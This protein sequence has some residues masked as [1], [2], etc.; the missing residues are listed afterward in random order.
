MAIT[1]LNICMG[2]ANLY[3]G[4]FGSVEP[5][6]GVLTGTPSSAV[7]TDVGAIA[8]GT[9]VLLEVDQTYTE[10]SAEQTIDPLGAR[11][12]KRTIQVTASLEEVTLANM[13][14]AMNGLT[15]INPQ[16]TYSVLDPV[17]GSAQSQPVYTALI[18]DGWAPTAGTTETSCRRRIVIRKCL[19][20]SKVDIEYEKAKPSLFACVWT[21][22]YV[23]G[24]ITPFE[25]ID[26]TS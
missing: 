10:I 12:T 3:F 6:Y 13:T 16:A 17:T 20:N 14:L 23:S 7:W 5:A 25:I 11:L 8:D 2:P 15:S 19:S 9:S 18:I 4:A 24:T 21:A 22:Y 26:Q 1:P